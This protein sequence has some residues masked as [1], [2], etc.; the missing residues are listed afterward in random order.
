[1]QQNGCECCFNGWEGYQMVL[2][3]AERESQVMLPQDVG[4]PMVTSN[5]VV[6]LN[7]STIT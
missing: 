4:F 1:M 2:L 7:M 3:E 6:R 5:L